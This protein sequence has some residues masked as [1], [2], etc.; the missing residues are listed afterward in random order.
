LVDGSLVPVDRLRHQPEGFVHDLVHP[1]R[2]ELFR[3]P[4][5]FDYV[6]EED[7]DPFPLAFQGTPHGED[8]FGE[9][10]RGVGRRPD[11]GC[12]GHQRSA[13][14]T[15]EMIERPVGEMAARTT[16]REGFT[17]R[18]TKQPRSSIVYA[19]SLADHR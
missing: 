18:G 12:A 17:T 7:G 3:Q 19:A 14:A 6:A 4:V 11:A 10:L 16:L 15:A 5:G 9:M 8:A 13:A 2:A 1:F